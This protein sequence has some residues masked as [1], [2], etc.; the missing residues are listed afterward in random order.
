MPGDERTR[1]PEPW[2]IHESES[3]YWVQDAAG[4]RF[5][6]CYFADPF[7]PGIHAPAVMPKD[8]A[9]RIVANIA[10]LPELLKQ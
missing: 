6:F 2:T 4:H 9:R 3:A 1:F 8:D 5:G 7:R 10:K